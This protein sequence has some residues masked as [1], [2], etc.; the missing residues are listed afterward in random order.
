[1]RVCMVTCVNVGMMVCP[2]D[3]HTS[4]GLP[5]INN[6]NPPTTKPRKHNPQRQT[7]AS[8]EDMEKKPTPHSTTTD[9]KRRARVRKLKG[10]GQRKAQQQ[11]Q[12]DSDGESDVGMT[13]ED[14]LNLR[15]VDEG[16]WVSSDSEGEDE[17]ITAAAMARHKG[18]QQGGQG[19]GAGVGDLEDLM[20]DAAV[21]LAGVGGGR[22]KERKGEGEG[23]KGVAPPPREMVTPMQ[24]GDVCVCVLVWIDRWMVC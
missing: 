5:T 10:Q 1:M 13:E 20:P 9:P 21:P 19:Q 23:G 7:A 4:I 8:W 12:G 14:R 6:L 15:L 16:E 11:G 18:G 2:T 3:T 24:V 22:G 17:G